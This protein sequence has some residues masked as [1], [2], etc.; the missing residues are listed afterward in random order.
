[1]KKSVFLLLLVLAS[2]PI[3]AQLTGPANP[4]PILNNQNFFRRLPQHRPSLSLGFSAMEPLR[5]FADNYDGIPFGISGQIE[6]PI[7]RF[8][9]LELGGDFAWYSRGGDRTD[10]LIYEGQDFNGNESFSDGT[11]KI[12][13]NIYSYSGFVRLNPVAGAFQFYGDLIVGVQNFST[14]T[15]IESEDN[16]TEPSRE[17]A[18]RGFSFMT[19]WAAGIKIRLVEQMYLEAR[20]ANLRGSDVTMVDKNSIFTDSEG[21]LEFEE[22]T[23]PTDH[24]VYQIGVSFVL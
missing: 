17:R 3:L 11:L 4:N 1:M 6:F 14:N 10:I 16:L 20:F 2:S 18:H 23:T 7:G 5:M 13:S 24:H 21:N 22:L 19:G 8:I 12:R 9:P 15:I